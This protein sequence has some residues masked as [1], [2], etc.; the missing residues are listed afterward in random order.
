[1]VSEYLKSEE[2]VEV[3]PGVV[4][5]STPRCEVHAVFYRNTALSKRISVFIEF[6]KARLS[7]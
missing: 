6:L 5:Q 2:L 7:L 4:D 3:L 1:M